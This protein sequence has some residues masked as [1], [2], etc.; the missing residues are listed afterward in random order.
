MSISVSNLTKLYD[1]Q[2]A[3]DQ[4]NFSVD[5]G[6]IVGFLGP[7]GAGKSTTMKILTGYLPSSSGTATVCGL[8]VDRQPLEVKKKVGYL[9]EANPLYMD[10]YVK[11]MLSFT[12]GLF[13]L[14]NKKERIEEV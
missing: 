3:L 8:D 12:A 9:P 4:I 14:S 5:K 13:H 10:M 11:E 2:K 1:E 7:N 6:E